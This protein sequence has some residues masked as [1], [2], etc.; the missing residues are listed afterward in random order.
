MINNKKQIAVLLATYNG[1]KYLETQLDSLVSQTS[2]DFKV[3]I[4]DDGSKDNTVSII[5]NY[6]GRYPDLF[7]FIGSHSTGGP[8]N[9]FMYLLSNVEST[10]YMFCD[11]DDYWLKDKIQITF[12]EMIK[13]DKMDSTKPYLVCTDLDLVD[14]E[15]NSLYGSFFGYRSFDISDTSIKNLMKRNYVMGCTMMIN[16]KMKEFASGKVDLKNI[17]MH[18]WWFALIASQFGK[19]KVIPTITIKYRQ[20]GNNTSGSSIKASYKELLVQIIH[21]RKSIKD[22]RSVRDRRVNFA[23]ELLKYLSVNDD[24]FDMITDLS[25]LHSYSKLKRIKIYSKYDL[26]PLNSNVIWENIWM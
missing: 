5:N 18:D 12:D 9:N 24:N 17:Y 11:Q 8:V 14:C 6:V 13:L 19:L 3:Y 23:K 21:F 4:H 22:K 10:Y 20:H 2:H 25:K 7:E 16:Q 1:E 15:L 26:Y